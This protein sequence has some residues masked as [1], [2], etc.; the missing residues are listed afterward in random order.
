MVEEDEDVDFVDDHDADDDNSLVHL[1]GAS[2]L[3]EL[4]VVPYAYR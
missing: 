1:V 4:E 3:V 2:K